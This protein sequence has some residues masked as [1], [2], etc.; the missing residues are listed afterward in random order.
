M[1]VFPSWEIASKENKFAGRNTS[2]WRS[3]EFDR[4]YKSAEAEMDPVKRAA[5]LIRMNDLVVQ[6]TVVI[7]LVWRNLVSGVS[8]KLKGTEISGWDSNFWNLAHWYR[9]A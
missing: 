6:N 9:E 3:E 8:G 2:R 4:L 1:R 5:A 7:P